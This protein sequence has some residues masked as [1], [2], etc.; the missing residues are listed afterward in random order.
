MC[1]LHAKLSHFNNNNNN[2]KK[3]KDLQER[4]NKIKK[5]I[6]QLFGILIFL[7]QKM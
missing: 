5:E 1:S 4:K 2:N 3:I 7:F 6:M